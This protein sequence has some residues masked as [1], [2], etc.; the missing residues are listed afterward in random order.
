[1]AL[2][3]VMARKQV[4]S[5]SQLFQVSLAHTPYSAPCPPFPPSLPLVLYQ[6]KSQ[7]NRALSLLFGMAVVLGC[8]KKTWIWEVGGNVGEEGAERAFDANLSLLICSVSILIEAWKLIQGRGGHGGG[9]R[10]S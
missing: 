5:A 1:M 10:G 8:G 9:R 3:Q 4:L 6:D 2:T 7:Q